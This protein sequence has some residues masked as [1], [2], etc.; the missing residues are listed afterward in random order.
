MAK[1]T[2]FINGV[3]GEDTTLTG[4]ISQF[5]AFESPTEVEVFINS[6]G[7]YV[8]AGEDIYNYLNALEIPVTTIASKAYSIAATIFMAGDS[9]LV[10]DVESPLMIHMPLIQGLTGNSKTLNAVAEELEK[11]E[12]KFISFYTALIDIP[13][14]TI[15]ALLNNETFLSAD[16]SVSLGFATGKKEVL[17]AVAFYEAPEKSKSPMSKLKET[18]TAIALQL[19][20]IEAPA[21][22][23]LVLQDATGVEVDFYELDAEDTPSVDDKARIDGVDAEG[24]VVFP[25]GETFKFTAGVLTEIVPAAADPV[26]EPTEEEAAAAAAA[27]EEAAKAETVKEVLKWEIEVNETA[28]EE[29]SQLTYSYDENT[30]NLGAGEFELEDGR[31]AVTDSS[32]IVVKIKPAEGAGTDPV[33][34]PTEEAIHEERLAAVLEK[35]TE[36]NT[37]LEAQIVALKKAVGSAEIDTEERPK[38]TAELTPLEL[39]RKSKS[40]I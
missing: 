8:A 18:V 17:K 38:P 10:E 16:E 3:I 6:N 23:A 37:A 27:A 7:G 21:P 28:I 12:K 2:I 22:V 14:D 39:Y 1:A 5:K 13:K 35:L 34:E 11:L 4:V 15:E 29:G 9:R 33:E 26:E 19:G 24:D 20:I 30:F 32:G 36:K 40:Q 31:R 25:S